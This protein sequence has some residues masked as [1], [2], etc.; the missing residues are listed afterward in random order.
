L[1]DVA[2]KIRSLADTMDIPS[3]SRAT[4]DASIS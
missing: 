4:Q 1:E 2:T 3:E